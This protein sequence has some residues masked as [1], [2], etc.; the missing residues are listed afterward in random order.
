MP[1]PRGYWA[2]YRQWQALGAQ[3]RKGARGTLILFY[4]VDDKADEEAEATERSH[5]RF[6]A[7]PSWVFNAGQ[8][9]GWDGGTPAQEDHVERW[10]VIEDVVRAR[11]ADV[12]YG[13]HRACYHPVEDFIEMPYAEWFV[14]G[15][16]RSATESF[17][18]T[19]LHE[20]T[21]WSGHASRLDRDLS[22]RFGGEAYAMEELVAELGAAFL[23]GN[24]GISN[25]PRLDHASYLSSW[26]TVLKRDSKA[27]VTAAGKAATAADFVLQGL[28]PQTESSA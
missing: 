1:L 15:Y 13:S 10:E 26:L 6:I 19:L 20:L 11:A 17:Y 12:R 9:D 5:R 25:E 28:A 16:A 23:C 7:R 8:V 2:S 4:L 27:L 21:H 3:V 24:L 22:G 18:S 14:S